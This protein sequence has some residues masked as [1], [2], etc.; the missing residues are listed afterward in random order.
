MV[1][2]KMEKGILFMKSK[3]KIVWDFLQL[4]EDIENSIF[5]MIFYF[6]DILD[7][8]FHRYLQK[9]VR[10]NQKLFLKKENFFLNSFSKVSLPKDIWLL[11]QKFRYF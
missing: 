10:T 9:L 5:F 8:L 2:A 11:Y 6:Q 7:Y 4:K 3:D 1:P